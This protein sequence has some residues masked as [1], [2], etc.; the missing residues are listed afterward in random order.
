MGT[1]EQQPHQANSDPVDAGLCINT[2][3]TLGIQ[4]EGTAG[5]FLNGCCCI[6]MKN[7]LLLSQVNV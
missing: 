5:Q 1:L 2:G 6:R 7:F 4:G 3:D